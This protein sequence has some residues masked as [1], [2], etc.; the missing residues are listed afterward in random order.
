M[1]QLVMTSQDTSLLESIHKIMLAACS[2][3]AIQQAR[4]QPSQKSLLDELQSAALA[5]PTHGANKFD[6]VKA[7]KLASALVESIIS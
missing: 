7:A 3:P 4:S 5:D 6:S 2:E 1:N